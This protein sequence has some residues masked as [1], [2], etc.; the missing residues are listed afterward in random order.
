MGFG[1]IAN[2]RVQ[3]ISALETLL[4]SSRDDPFSTAVAGAFD[5]SPQFEVRVKLPPALP[6]QPLKHVKLPRITA[7]SAQVEAA[8]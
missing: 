3:S 7:Q 4:D 6:P 1:C 8:W 2:T 5:N